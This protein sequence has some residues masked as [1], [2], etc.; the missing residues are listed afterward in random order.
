LDTPGL[1]V[2]LGYD[3]LTCEQTLP[4]F[5]GVGLPLDAGHAASVTQ[6]VHAV[7][8]APYSEDTRDLKSW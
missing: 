1:W 5:K 8:N 4:L 2:K 7:D 6:N 3:V